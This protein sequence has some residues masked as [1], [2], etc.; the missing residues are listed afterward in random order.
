MV[1]LTRPTVSIYD[2]KTVDLPISSPEI[3]I[4]DQ[5][6]YAYKPYFL[7]FPSYYKL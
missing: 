6:I 5:V 4:H 7:T 3:D 1:A 2:A